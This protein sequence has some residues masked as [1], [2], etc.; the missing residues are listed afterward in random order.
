PPAFLDEI[1]IRVPLSDVVGKQLRLTRRGREFIG[2]CPFHRE[3]S[4][5]FSVV[6][7]KGFFHC[8]GCGA[9]GDVIGFLMRTENL[10]FPEAVERLAGLAGLE[11]PQQSPAEREQERRAATLYDVLEEASVWFEQ[12]LTGPDGGETRAYLDRRGVERDTAE[13][14]RLGYA[15]DGRNRLIRHL[16]AKGATP[17]LIAAAGL[18]AGGDDGRDPIDRF[19]HRL[20]FPIGDRSGRI[21]AFGGRTM[22]D[23]PAKYLNSPET[24]VFSKGRVLYGYAQARKPAHEAGMVIVAEGYMDVIALAQAGF[25]HA[26]A[27]LGTALTEGQLALL[28]RLAEE[29]VLCFDGDQ[30]GQRAAVRAIERALPGL[31]PGK[32]LGFAVLPPGLD[33]DDLIKARGSRG[34]KEILDN[35]LPLLDMLWRSRTESGRFDTPERRAGLEKELQASVEQIGDRIVQFHYQSAIRE[36]L[37][38]AFGPV[39]KAAPQNRRDNRNRPGRRF[40]GGWQSNSNEF[41]R[42]P[43]RAPGVGFAG[44]RERAER[45]LL[46]LPVSHG[47]LLEGIAERLAEVEFA[48][49][50]YDGLRDRLLDALNLEEILDSEALQRHLTASGLSELLEELMREP[51]GGAVDPSLHVETVEEAERLWHHVFDLRQQ[52]LFKEEIEA[53]AAA[54]SEE[55]SGEDWQR[56]QAKQEMRQASET[57]LLALD[58]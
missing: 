33:P 26:V 11:M 18:S 56:L 1:R 42:K 29:P 54:W 31:L 37:R 5:S 27:P 36:R 16:A 12:Q 3:K 39:R 44:E 41:E 8:F 43:S 10:G 28:W 9:H 30:A 45:L 50:G 34:M 22:G 49:P 6:E 47:S 24:P 32:S 15:P 7:D 52:R 55:K 51:T 46:A 14:F 23:H 58:D 53:D 21:I 20:I 2:L 38:R 4:P 48:K 19:R 35:A 25:R 17:Q 13:R 57:K 40:Q